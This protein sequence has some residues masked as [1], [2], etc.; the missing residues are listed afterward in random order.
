MSE[1]DLCW[2]LQFLLTIPHSFF[3]QPLNFYTH[4]ASTSEDPGES[5]KL[6]QPIHHRDFIPTLNVHLNLANNAR[7]KDF[8][9]EKRLR[10]P[11]ELNKE[12]RYQPATLLPSYRVRWF[13]ASSIELNARLLGQRLQASSK[14]S[15]TTKESDHGQSPRWPMISHRT[16]HRKLQHREAS[17]PASEAPV[18]SR[19][20]FFLSFPMCLPLAC[21]APRSSTRL[22]PEADCGHSKR[23]Q[24]RLARARAN[25]KERPTMVFSPLR[26]FLLSPSPPDS[27]LFHPVTSATYTCIYLGASFREAPKISEGVYGVKKFGNG[28]R[29]R[30]ETAGTV[31]SAIRAYP[32][33]LSLGCMRWSL[34]ENIRAPHKFI[35]SLLGDAGYMK[36]S[37]FITPTCAF[38]RTVARGHR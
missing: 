17:F 7:G 24:A 11:G 33:L 22:Q 31:L 23:Q 20:P 15:G 26:S 21:I 37:S 13:F 12:T 4:S 18:A 8:T 3:H 5:V 9:R 36:M 32:F 16:R 1:V 2:C 25:S 35:L 28:D 34:S 38:I 27:P 6:S 30:S 29:A 19:M 10:K 14:A